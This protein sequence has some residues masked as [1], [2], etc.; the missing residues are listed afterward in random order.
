MKTEGRIV[1][2]DGLCNL[3]SGGARWLIRVGTLLASP[4]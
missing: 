1:V 3:C 4:C 2:F